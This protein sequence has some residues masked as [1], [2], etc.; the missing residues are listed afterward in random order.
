[1]LVLGEPADDG[2]LVAVEDTGRHPDDS[3]HRIVDR[4]WRGV[5]RARPV[6]PAQGSDSRSG[7][8]SWRPAG[9]D[10][11]REPGK[12]WG[13]GRLHARARIASRSAG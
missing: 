11:D 13:E 3:L 4:F 10:L 1:M 8:G 2:V 6:E 9:Q 12:W 5:K 7:A